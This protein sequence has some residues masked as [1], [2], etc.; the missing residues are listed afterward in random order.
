MSQVSETSCIWYRPGVLQDP[1]ASAQ[2]TRT[3]FYPRNSVLGIPI[4]IIPTL[5]YPAQNRNS[6]Q[7]FERECLSVLGTAETPERAA[8]RP[9]R[10]S[11]TTT[12]SSS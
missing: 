8:E 12:G 7:A 6:D 10:I 9:Q 5:R 3:L 4:P 11:S 2:N 1:S